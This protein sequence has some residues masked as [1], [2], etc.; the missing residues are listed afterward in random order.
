MK[1]KITAVGI[2]VAMLST[3]LSSFAANTADYSDIPQGWAKD[4]IV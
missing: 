1:K 3:G 4:A 2:V